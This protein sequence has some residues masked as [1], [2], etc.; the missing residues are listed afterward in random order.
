[1]IGRRL[2]IMLLLAISA[3][4]LPAPCVADSKLSEACAAVLS[5]LPARQPRL[6]DPESELA[7]VGYAAA[8]A[9][10]GLGRAKL[11]EFAKLVR[12]NPWQQIASPV[13]EEILELRQLSAD[14][15]QRRTRELAA[16]VLATLQARLGAMNLGFHFN[17]HGGRPLDYLLRGGIDATLGDIRL[18]HDH[19]HVPVPKVYFFRSDVSLDAILG[20][21]HPDLVFLGRMGTSLVIFDTRAPEL[22]AAR[23]R[24]AII[25]EDEISMTFQTGISTGYAGVSSDAYLLPPI[26]LDW[27]LSPI[28]GLWWMTRGEKTWAMLRYLEQVAENWAR[29]KSG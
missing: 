29:L 28:L 26:P 14:E 18:Q 1:M 24:G 11:E 13:R 3:S 25:R 12:S 23:E 7:R 19:R 16:R 21:P 22:E 4:V 27:N 8:M 5:N 10:P 9:R 6:H 2:E 20:E 17:L 15:R